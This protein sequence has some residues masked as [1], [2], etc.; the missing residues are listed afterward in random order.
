[1][2]SKALIIRLVIENFDLKDKVND[3]LSEYNE[4]DLKLSDTFMELQEL[5]DYVRRLETETRHTPQPEPEPDLTDD[6]A[7][8][9]L[10]IKLTGSTPIREVM[11]LR[12]QLK[13]ESEERDEWKSKYDDLY[14]LVENM[15]SAV[16]TTPTSVKTTAPKK[17]VIDHEGDV[18]IDVGIDPNRAKTTPLGRKRHTNWKMIL[19]AL[20]AEKIGTWFNVPYASP[21]SLKTVRRYGLEYKWKGDDLYVRLPIPTPPVSGET[22]V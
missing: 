14:S 19:T 15:T 16:S 4:L 7:L 11:I 8:Q 20:H 5:R 21:T 12:E 18:V 3:C 9:A 22:G 2:K 10:R 6:E 17:Q 13:A 1:M